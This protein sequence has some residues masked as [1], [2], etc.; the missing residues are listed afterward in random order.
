V[1]RSIK[2]FNILMFVMGN[3]GSMFYAAQKYIYL[4]GLM[5]RKRRLYMRWCMMI[6]GL[7]IF[8][9]SLGDEIPRGIGIR[10][11]NGLFLML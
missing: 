2:S 5:T 11:S 4:N 3:N 7:T 1:A 10:E 6:V 9:W 8:G